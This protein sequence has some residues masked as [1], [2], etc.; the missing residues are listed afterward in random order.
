MPSKSQKNLTPASSAE[1]RAWAAENV[2][3][4]EA[5]KVSTAFLNP[6]SGKVRGRVPEGARVLF[7]EA[8]GRPAAE[9]S[10]AETKHIDLTLTKRDKA[11]RSR[12]KVTESFPVAEVRRLGGAPA[13]GR[14]SSAVIAQAVDRIQADRGW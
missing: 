13:K 9:K 1:V 5:A 6:P 11:G 2:P 3:A 8:T 14:L 12:G 10:V 7:T 4:L